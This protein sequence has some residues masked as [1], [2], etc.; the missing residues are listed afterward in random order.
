MDFDSDQV[1]IKRIT[2]KDG[3]EIKRV[4]LILIKKEI[5]EDYATQVPFELGPN[6]DIFPF[7]NAERVLYTDKPY[8]SR[9]EEEMDG[10]S[11]LEDDIPTEID[12]DSSA[13]LSMV[14]E[15][16]EVTDPVK[17]DQALQEITDGL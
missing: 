9:S 11:Y 8:E 5:E 14:D 2:D 12:S 4:K 1:Q 7:T 16:F 3:K 6:E 13:T 17:I 10:E 15:D